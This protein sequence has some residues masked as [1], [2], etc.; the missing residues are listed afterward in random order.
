MSI[1]QRE[2]R[3]IF[4]CILVFMVICTS[5]GSSIFRLV[6]KHTDNILDRELFFIYPA[7]HLL[8]LLHYLPD[9]FKLLFLFFLLLF[10]FLPVNATSHNAV[11]VSLSHLFPSQFSKDGIC[12]SVRLIQQP[13]H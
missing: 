1:F 3:F 2:V 7:F 13:W 6:E 8:R 10:H 11:V 12:P 9:L 5:F 4:S